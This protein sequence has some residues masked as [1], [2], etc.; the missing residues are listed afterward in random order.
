MP[1]G[2]A[3]GKR[4]IIHRPQAR[5]LWY[6]RLRGAD[7]FLGSRKSLGKTR[8]HHT[9]IIFP[10]GLFG[11]LTERETAKPAFRGFPA[12]VNLEANRDE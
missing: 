11:L 9:N 1:G 5:K 7:N 8:I 4:G 12:R 6:A 10:F 2:K 3:D